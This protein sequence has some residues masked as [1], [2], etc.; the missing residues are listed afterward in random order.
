MYYLD[1]GPYGGDVQAAQEEPFSLQVFSLK[2]QVNGFLVFICLILFNNRREEE[3]Q[4]LTCGV[5]S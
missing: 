2:I 1:P 3:K 5:F 4:A